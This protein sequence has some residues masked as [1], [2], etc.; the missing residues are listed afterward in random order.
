MTS[1]MIGMQMSTKAVTARQRAEGRRPEGKTASRRYTPAISAVHAPEATAAAAAP[2]GRPASG[3]ANTASSAYPARTN[4]SRL[5]TPASVSAQPTRLPGRFT[6]MKPPT[7]ANASVMT[8]SG[9]AASSVSLRPYDESDAR[10]TSKHDDAEEEQRGQRARRPGEDAVPA[11][12]RHRGSLS[13]SETWAGCIVSFTAAPRSVPSSSRSTSSRRRALKASRVCCGV[14]AAAVEAAVDELL[15]AGAGRAEERGDGERRAGDGEVVAA[16]ESAEGLLEPDH[17]A[18]VEAGEEGGDDRV[19]DRPV[20]DPVE[21]VHAVAE[22]REAHGDREHGEAERRED[23]PDAVERR[24]PEEERT[25]EQAQRR[26]GTARP[27]PT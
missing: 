16:G 10:S 12:A 11:L 24:P 26:E 5:A 3:S 22:N 8:R 21:V 13:Q 23:V 4:P 6:V 7:S 17:D 1:Q 19:D 18:E 20:D 27:P 14:V 9:T 15:D 2:P 25:A